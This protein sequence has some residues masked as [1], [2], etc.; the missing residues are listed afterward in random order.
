MTTIL[1]RLV[2]DPS[3]LAP[4]GKA[5]RRRVFK[6]FTW[7]AKADQVMTVY[8][9][10]MRRSLQRPDFGMPLPDPRHDELFDDFTSQDIGTLNGQAYPTADAVPTLR[11]QA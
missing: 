11:S 3:G 6:H 9:Y 1:N 5:A 7:Q 8:R 4:L 2:E 10:V